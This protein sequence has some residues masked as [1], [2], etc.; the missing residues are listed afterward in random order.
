MY[1]GDARVL[2]MRSME[3]MGL[4]RALRGL[5]DDRA[6]EH[7]VREVLQIMSHHPG[8]WLPA[9]DVARRA[10]Q[11]EHQVSVILSKLAAGYVLSAD[12]ARFR[13]DRDPVVDMEI[14]RFLNKSEIHSK[15]AQN[16]L[17]RFRDRYSPH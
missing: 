8:E 13:Y 2:L 4:D 15:L 3:K 11:P 10:E 12:G 17:A 6:A 7:A 5:V 14:R 1:D 9:S 16:N